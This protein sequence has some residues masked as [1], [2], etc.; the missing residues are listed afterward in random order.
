MVEDILRGPN[1]TQYNYLNIPQE[2]NENSFN[3]RFNV[4]TLYNIDTVEWL[5]PVKHILIFSALK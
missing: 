1:I 4:N 3:L 2:Q 5:T